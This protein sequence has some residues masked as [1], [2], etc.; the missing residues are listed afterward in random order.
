[1]AYGTANEALSLFSWLKIGSGEVSKDLDK[2]K[3]K[4]SKYKKTTALCKPN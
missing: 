4:K 2:F 1:M 3:Y